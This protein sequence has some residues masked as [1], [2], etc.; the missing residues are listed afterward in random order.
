[1]ASVLGRRRSGMGGNRGVVRSLS[2]VAATV[3]VATAP[4]PPVAR[5][6]PCGP[7]TPFAWRPLW[8]KWYILRGP[9]AGRSQW[10]RRNGDTATRR[11]P[12]FPPGESAAN[13][14]RRGALARGQKTAETPSPR[15]KRCRGLHIA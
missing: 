4:G 8:G 1:M 5:E 7:L 2:G 11:Q 12:R 6:G 9:P 3:R 14:R 10:E 15:P 13:Q